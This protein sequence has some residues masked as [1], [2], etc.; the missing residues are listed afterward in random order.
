MIGFFSSFQNK[1]DARNPKSIMEKCRYGNLYLPKN[2][3]GK[4]RDLVQLL[5]VDDSELRLE[6]SQIK[7]HNFFREIDWNLL[8]K[9]RN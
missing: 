6:I 3:K 7:D 8:K 1:E 9:K 4:T 2:L 5:L